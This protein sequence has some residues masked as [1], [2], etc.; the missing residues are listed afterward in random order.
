MAESL[1]RC[2]L[3]PSL[4]LLP[5]RINT[6]NKNKQ[7]VPRTMFWLHE[8]STWCV[9]LAGLMLLHHFYNNDGKR[10]HTNFLVAMDTVRLLVCGQLVLPNAFAMSWLQAR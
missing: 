6:E 3:L 4:Y 10:G 7:S 2:G 8:A 9:N 5:C 1:G